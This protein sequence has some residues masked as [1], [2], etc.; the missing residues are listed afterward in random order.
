M[1]EA[2]NHAYALGAGTGTLPTAST[3]LSF[4]NGGSGSLTITTL[5]GES[6]TLSLPSGMY[7]IRAAAITANTMTNLVAWW[8]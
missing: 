5:G 7:P 3:W 4:V 1:Y 2:P 8:S 6:V